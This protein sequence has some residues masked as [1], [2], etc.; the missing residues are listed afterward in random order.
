MHNMICVCQAWL[1][2]TVITL[3]WG[4]V[5]RIRTKES[6]E[7]GSMLACQ[8]RN[9][10]NWIGKSTSGIMQ[11]TH[12]NNVVNELNSKPPLKFYT[13]HFRILSGWIGA[14]LYWDWW[15]TRFTEQGVVI[16]S[17]E[18]WRTP[19]VATGPQFWRDSVAIF[20]PFVQGKWDPDDR[21]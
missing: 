3:I 7:C 19:P 2:C 18:P 21:I 17:V 15:F 16:P 4:T 9:A 10:P 11:K 1:T 6:N 8:V 13:T 14:L 20:S 5:E 12:K